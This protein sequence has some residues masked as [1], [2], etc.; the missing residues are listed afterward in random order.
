MPTIVTPIVISKLSDSPL[1]PFIRSARFAFSQALPVE[2]RA[3]S[4]TCL[5]KAPDCSQGVARSFTSF[6][7]ARFIARSV[8]EAETGST[9]SSAAQAK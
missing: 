5:S 6:S 4:S 1:R 7:A 9:G 2:D 3:I 8:V